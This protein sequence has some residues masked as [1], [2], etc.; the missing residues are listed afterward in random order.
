MTAN[1]SASLFSKE[2]KHCPKSPF[3][4]MADLS[5]AVL[6]F[7][8]VKRSFAFGKWK[9]ENY[10]I[11]STQKFTPGRM[12]VAYSPDGRSVACASSTDSKIQVID[13]DTKGIVRTLA[14]NARVNSIAFSPDGGQLAAKCNRTVQVWNLGTGENVLQI[15]TDASFGSFDDRIEFSTDG[16]RIASQNQKLEFTS[17]MPNPENRRLRQKD[18]RSLGYIQSKRLADRHSDTR[19]NQDLGRKRWHE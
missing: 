11:H 19:W 4:V 5:Q 6:L 15:D 14:A 18:F 8:E 10:G 12:W 16:T 3:E 9:P 13:L 2:Q 7:R 1:W 17:G